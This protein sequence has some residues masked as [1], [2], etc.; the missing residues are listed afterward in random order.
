[1][2][3]VLAA[4]LG[5]TLF[6]GLASA[7][8]SQFKMYDRPDAAVEEF[9]NVYTSLV[10][11]T[12]GAQSDA[13]ATLSNKLQG[14]CELHVDPNLRSYELKLKSTS[15]GSK[16][17]VGSTESSTIK[18]T[19]H[20]SRRCRDKVSAKILVVETNEN[21]KTTKLFSLD[22][23]PKNEKSVTIENAQ[24]YQFFKALSEAGVSSYQS[25]DGAS[26]FEA[27]KVECQ[28]PVVAN[29]SATCTIA[30]QDSETMTAKGAAAKTLFET[31]KDIGALIKPTV[32]GVAKARAT[33]VSCKVYP[34]VSRKS[35]T[36]SLSVVL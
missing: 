36:C 27:T 18:V 3:K 21:G 13:E 8:T 20:R 34:I 24:A 5:L 7:A 33:S 22:G 2:E 23:K 25:D 11:K 28:A 9:C 29:P 12:P 30:T 26:V 15:C 17:Y 10:L 19:D 6:A 16:Y 35:P 31:L 4:S 1:M 14:G 32:I